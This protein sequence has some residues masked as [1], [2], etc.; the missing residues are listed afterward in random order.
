[1]FAQHVPD[2]GNVGAENATERLEDR[3]CAERNVVPCEVRT[4]ATE[5]Y[6]QAYGGYDAC[7]MRK[8]SPVAFG[9]QK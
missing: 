5:D 6:G 9:V 7:A 3:I 1:M 2:D 4:T 8:V